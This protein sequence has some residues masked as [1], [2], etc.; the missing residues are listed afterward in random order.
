MALRGFALTGDQVLY[1]NR[2]EKCSS[3]SRNQWWVAHLKNRLAI[4]SELGRG[5]IGTNTILNVVSRT[6][7]TARQEMSFEAVWV[8]FLGGGQHGGEAMLH[9]SRPLSVGNIEQS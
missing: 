3:R 5:A 1:A 2:W 9:V 7:L 4:K 6:R 8:L